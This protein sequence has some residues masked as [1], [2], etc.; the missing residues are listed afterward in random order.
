MYPY[1]YLNLAVLLKSRGSYEEAINI[2]S[3][4]IE[5]NSDEDFLFITEHAFL[6]M[7]VVFRKQ[8]RI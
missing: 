1:S 7:K 8:W 5:N 6:P 3:E 4:G 2:I